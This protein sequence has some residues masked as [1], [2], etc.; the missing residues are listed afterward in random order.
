MWKSALGPPRDYL[1][2]AS[3]YLRTKGYITRGDNAALAITVDGVDFVEE[4]RVSIPVLQKLL[5]D[6][7]RL[8]SSTESSCRAE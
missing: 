7:H 8:G 3:W 4:Q 5:T 2:F 6:R 1:E